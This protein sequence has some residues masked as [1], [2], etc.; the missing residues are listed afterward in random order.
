MDPITI[1]T[2]VSAFIRYAPQLKAGAQDV[3]EGA[4]KIWESVS[5]EHPPTDIQRTEYDEALR[6]AHEALQRS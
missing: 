3:I 1:L 2:L 4:Q 6:V 5:A